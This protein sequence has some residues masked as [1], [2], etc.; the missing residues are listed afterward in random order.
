VAAAWSQESVMGLKFFSKTVAAAGM[1]LCL[2]ACNSVSLGISVPIGGIG[3]VGVGADSSGRVSGGV[4]VGTGGVSVGVGGTG[5][6]PAS[7]K[8]PQPPASAASAGN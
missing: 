7:P 5:T 3:S 8:A 6:L 2:A 4:A 1:L